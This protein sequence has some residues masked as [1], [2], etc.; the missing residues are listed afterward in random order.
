[1]EICVNVVSHGE[2]VPGIERLNRVL[3]ERARCY[4]AMVAEA[5]ILSLP[6]TVV[7][8]I[9]FTVN[10]YVNSFVWRR[11]VSQIIPLIIIV[12]GTVIDF[13]KHFRVI[14][15]EYCHTYEALPMT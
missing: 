15:G 12:E 8:H 1:M 6:K 10:F 4:Y 9:I 5:G 11:G 2:H 7:M 14:F 3:K 13:E